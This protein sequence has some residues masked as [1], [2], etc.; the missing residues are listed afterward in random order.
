MIAEDTVI[1]V[2]VKAL[3][4]GMRHA[5]CV[6]Y[7]RR[8]RGRG[9]GSESNSRAERESEGDAEAEAEGEGGRRRR[10]SPRKADDK[11]GSDMIN[12]G[13]CGELPKKPLNASFSI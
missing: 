4:P 9:R 5:G 10:R 6:W 7:W 12:W 13:Y 8:G 11:D 2:L 3:R 1:S